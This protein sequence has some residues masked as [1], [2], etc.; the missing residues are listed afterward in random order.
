[1]RCEGEVRFV[2][3]SSKVQIAVAG[4]LALLVLSWLAT[5]TGVAIAR[6]VAAHDAESVLNREARVIRAESRVAAYRQSVRA[7]AADLR[8][9]QDF[10]DAMVAAHIGDLPGGRPAGG[11]AAGAHAARKLSLAVPEAAA[12]AGV[13][14]RQLAFAERLTRYADARAAADTAR[15]RGLG[16]NPDRELAA[17]DT[18]AGEGGPLLRLS[19]EA[20]GSLDPRFGRLGASLAR[21]DAL[22]Q[23][24]QRLPQVL[25]AN[26]Q[27]LSSGFG[28][29]LDPFTH[30]AAFHP[31]L[32]FRGPIGTPI[33]AAARGTVIFAGQ[34]SGYGNCV[35]IDH[36]G[37]LVTRYAHMSA[38]RAHQGER[39]AAG[40]VIG[41]IGS[42]GRSTGPHLHFEVRIDD[43]PVNPRPFLE[44]LTHVSEKTAAGAVAVND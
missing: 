10:I 20:D 26:P 22:E 12:L 30:G 3:L 31:G 16:L 40:E 33:L 43:R 29:R 37:G 18:G 25:P 2:T 28:Y 39:V 24:M 15:M 42:T 44:T 19:T 4:A 23:D 11:D 17:L 8:R 38:F 21:M 32:D 1:M 9:R 6:I 5:L 35:E 14:T 34:R 27:F 7:V 36:G 13:E 41:A